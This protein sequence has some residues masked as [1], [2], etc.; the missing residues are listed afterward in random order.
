MQNWSTVKHTIHSTKIPLIEPHFIFTPKFEKKKVAVHI[1]THNMSGYSIGMENE[2]IP[3]AVYYW[4]III[5]F[6]IRITITHSVYMPVY[7][8]INFLLRPKKQLLPSY[9]T[10][11]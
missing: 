1:I 6:C 4:S 2:F 11:Q 7:K 8:S 3:A 9:F 5:M 10:T